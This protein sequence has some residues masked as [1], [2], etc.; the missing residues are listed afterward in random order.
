MSYYR[1]RNPESDDT[2]QT[3]SAGGEL[4]AALVEAGLPVVAVQRIISALED[5]FPKTSTLKQQLDSLLAA[6][7]DETAEQKRLREEAEKENDRLRQ[8]FGQ[9]ALFV[10]GRGVVGGNLNVFGDLFTRNLQVLNNALIRGDVSA[11]QAFLDGLQVRGVAA[12]APGAAQFFAPLVANN[13]LLANAGG[14]YSGH[15]EFF[16]T[17]SV[18][19]VVWSGQQCQPSTVVLTQD[20]AINEPGPPEDPNPRDRLKLSTRNVRVLNDYG[21]GPIRQLRLTVRLADVTGVPQNLTSAFTYT[22]EQPLVDAVSSGETA[23]L[24]GVS[25]EISTASETVLT[26]V[27]VGHNYAEVLDSVTVSLAT[28]AATFLTTAGVSVSAAPAV[29]G[30]TA[31]VSSSA[32]AV[33]TT[34][35]I[36]VGSGTAV[37]SVSVTI[38]TSTA[39]VV[40]GASVTPAGQ[41]VLSTV[42]ASLATTPITVITAVGFNATSCQVT[43]QT[44]QIYAVSGS[45]SLTTSGASVLTGVSLTT[46]PSVVVGVGGAAQVTTSASSFLNAATVFSSATTVNSV[47]GSVAVTTST[48]SYVNA[49]TAFSDNSSVYGAGGSVQVT[50]TKAWVVNA[51]SVGKD[52]ATVY[53]VTGDLTVS[54]TATTAINAVTVSATTLPPVVSAATIEYEEVTVASTTGQSVRIFDLP[55]EF[56]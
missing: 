24:S 41:T 28:A 42:T 5:L 16:G 25:V 34:A 8:R 29:S 21:A 43:T 19:D 30:V 38:P 32:A 20:I 45:L 36:T 13:A 6:V 56:P 44:T 47:S 1:H 35:G 4:L 53:G 22:E 26:D 54:T 48:A 14:L 15:N 11:R 10:G 52:K 9:A 7:Q 50:D 3:Q 37:A 18:N 31:S 55:P 49:V 27:T 39:T 17:V 23:V 12:L 2:S 46:S 51:I 33:L 40:A